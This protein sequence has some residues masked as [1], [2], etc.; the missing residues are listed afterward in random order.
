M[1]NRKLIEDNPYRRL[2]VYVGDPMKVEVRNLNRIIAFSHVGQTAT[3]EMRNDD[4]MGPIER[5]EQ[6]AR[7]AANALSLP[8]ERLKHALL[9]MGD[10]S[11]EWGRC[12][13]DA[14]EA[15]LNEH[16]QSAFKNYIFLVAYDYMRK[17]LLQAATHGLLTLTAR[18]MIEV[19]AEVMVEYLDGMWSY[20]TDERTKYP[21]ILNEILW[22]KKS[23]EVSPLIE[24]LKDYKL[25]HSDIY[26]QIDM[27]NAS[28]NT[29]ALWCRSCREVWEP[30]SM[31]Y[32]I[33]ATD[34]AKG[35][36]SAATEI[37]KNLG[38][39][40]WRQRNV[41][42][43]FDANNTV[44]ESSPSAKLV[45]ASMALM[46]KVTATMGDF[47]GSLQLNDSSWLML[48]DGKAE[49]ENVLKSQYIRNEGAIQLALGR[50]R[51]RKAIE[52]AIWGATAAI[53]F[54]SVVF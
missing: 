48:E 6:T 29:L 53:I 25:P 15:L 49:F 52:L 41:S 18:E 8:R 7:E 42:E 37:I 23:G 9:W 46:E 1:A 40:T 35:A 5:T 21:L 14:V 12:L 45:R 17:E 39:I 36:Y 13:N 51:K 24:F 2:G 28:L 27:Y 4:L 26:T 50:Y 47:I 30:E 32:Q 44:Y 3:F 54:F 10:E 22:K 11:T 34:V 19:V 43:T 33:F 16:Y 20:W 38:M 31:E